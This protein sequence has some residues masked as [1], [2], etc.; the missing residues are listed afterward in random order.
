MAQMGGL[1]VSD[2]SLYFAQ[3]PFPYLRLGY[4]S[5]LSSWALLNSGTADSNYGYWYP[6]KNNDGGT[7]GGF[8]PRP[9]GRAWLGNKEMGRGSWW[10][11]GEIELGYNGALRSAAT[12]VADDP[13]FGLLAYGGEIVRAKNLIEVIPKDGLRAR[14][15][16]A[17][18]KQ[19]VHILLDGDGFAKDKPIS[20]D[21]ALSVIRFTLENRATASHEPLIRVAG[22]PA[23]SYEVTAQNHLAQ[24]LAVN[25]GEEQQLR[26]SVG[27]SGSSVS[28][29]RVSR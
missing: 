4:A 7:A 19:R 25:S 18:G 23:G 1:A 17:R 8:E 9:W 14:L 10:Y 2:Y 20:F 5:Y 26:V 16:I 21:D 15:H 24:K 11:S 29:E 13:I 12:I 3:D 6:G 22:L 28:I 27:A